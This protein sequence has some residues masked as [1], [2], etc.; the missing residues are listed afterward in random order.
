LAKIG[1]RLR[2]P[3]FPEHELQADEAEALAREAIQYLETSE[4]TVLLDRLNE[5]EPIPSAL[6]QQFLAQLVR[7]FQAAT[8]AGVPWNELSA[9]GSFLR[10][11]RLVMWDFFAPGNGETTLI[12]SMKAPT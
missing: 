11:G 3:A 9:A 12:S 8:E 4:Q 6:L 5:Y 7:L 2:N 10:S 1:A